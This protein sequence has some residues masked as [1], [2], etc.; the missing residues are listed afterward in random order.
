MR[1]VCLTSVF[2]SSAFLWHSC[3]L[4]PRAA[5]VIEVPRALGAAAHHRVDAQALPGAEGHHLVR[6]ESR[7]VRPV[8]GPLE[9][10]KPWFWTVPGDFA[11]VLLE[12][13]ILFDVCYRIAPGAIMGKNNV[14]RK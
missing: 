6:N 7:V 8:V 11:W 1:G 9:S 5:Q 12:A 13:M 14:I 10:L 3:A 4:C 2:F